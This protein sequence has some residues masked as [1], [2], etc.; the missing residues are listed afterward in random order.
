MRGRPG[1]GPVECGWV[2]S[3]PF[4]ARRAEEYG[5]GGR[6]LR[7]RSY[8]RVVRE[9]H[10]GPTE[11]AGRVPRYRLRSRMAYVL[12]RARGDPVNGPGTGPLPGVGPVCWRVPL[13]LPRPSPG[14]VGPHGTTVPFRVEPGLA[15]PERRTAGGSG[16]LPS[17]PARTRSGGEWGGNR[18]PTRPGGTP[19]RIT[20][21]GHRR[22]AGPKGEE[23]EEEAPRLPISITC[24]RVEPADPPS[25]RPRSLHRPRAKGQVGAVRS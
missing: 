8:A 13:L 5:G 25:I 23:A 4:P 24:A 19:R 2:R 7:A 11:I 18:D 21:E 12:S 22:P 14:P 20:G 3:H 16:L 15:S 17:S 9:R 6:K 1:A 10:P